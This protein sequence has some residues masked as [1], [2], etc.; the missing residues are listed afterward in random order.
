[1][2]WDGASDMP[3]VVGQVLLQALRNCASREERGH[4]KPYVLTVRHHRVDGV[5]R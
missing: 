2:L 1:M 5:P 3:L 4:P